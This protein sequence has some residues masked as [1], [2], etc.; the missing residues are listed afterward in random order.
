[1]RGE[2]GGDDMGK[3]AAFAFVAKD[4]ESRCE[5]DAAADF[6]SCKAVVVVVYTTLQVC[7]F[8]LG[9][10]ICNADAGLDSILNGTSTCALA[11]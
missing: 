9:L 5:G 3:I 1:M 11:R 2:D 10:L 8:L 4:W 7:L 6:K